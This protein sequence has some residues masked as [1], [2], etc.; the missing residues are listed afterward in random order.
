MSEPGEFSR[1]IDLR[2]IGPEPVKLSATAEE[3]AALARRFELVA[4]KRLE[5]QITLEPD[6]DAIAANG[7]L[8]AD[9]VQNCAISGDDLPQ[10]IREQLAM[11]F[12]PA[13]NA[14]ADPDEEIE[15]DADELDEMFFEGTAFDLGEAVAQSLALAIDPFAVGP[16]ADEARR[17]HGLLEE[18]AEGPLAD[19]LRQLR[20]D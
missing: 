1:M 10:K 3:R 20:K 17:A 12:V 2:S 15:L 9:I 13:K 6:G 18:G 8:S 19:A 5:A 16:E 14:P 11:R 4:I 7:T